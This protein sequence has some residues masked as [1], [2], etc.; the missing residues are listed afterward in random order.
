MTK[1]IVSD[2]RRHCAKTILA[3]FLNIMKKAL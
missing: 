1:I 3:Q 2:D